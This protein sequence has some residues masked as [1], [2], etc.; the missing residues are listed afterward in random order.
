MKQGVRLMTL[1]LGL[2]GTG[3]WLALWNTV[4]V[5]EAWIAAILVDFWLAFADHE[6]ELE[7]LVNTVE[8]LLVIEVCGMVADWLE[9]SAL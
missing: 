6:E 1:E 8:T 2:Y 5:C 4:L 3:G 7:E 9:R